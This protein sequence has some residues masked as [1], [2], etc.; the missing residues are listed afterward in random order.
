MSER[1]FAF[2]YNSAT[3][4]EYGQEEFSDLFAHGFRDG[5][6]YKRH[7][8]SLKV[9]VPNFGSASVEPGIMRMRGYFY[10][11]TT[12]ITLSLPAFTIGKSRT[13][14]VIVR[15]DT[16]AATYGIHA[17]AKK[18]TDG[19]T[20][21]PGLQNSGNVYELS[22]AQVK[23]DG[24][25]SVLVVAD[26]RDEEAVCGRFGSEVAASADL[27]TKLET[28]RL[29]GNAPFDGTK[30]ISLAEI[31]AMPA[32]TGVA[33]G[34]CTNLAISS[35]PGMITVGWDDPADSNWAGTLLVRK[36]IYGAWAHDPYPTS[37]TDGVVMLDNKVRNNYT[38]GLFY[39]RDASLD[40]QMT[41]YYRLFPYNA[42]GKVNM[43]ESNKLPSQSGLT[44][45]NWMALTLSSGISAANVAGG[46]LPRICKI[47]NHV[48]SREALPE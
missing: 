37:P 41:Y 16:S 11:N 13:D 38:Q 8:D 30:G 4:N 26:E 15:L 12:P 9:T 32:P 23:Y 48:P 43:S 3:D 1:Y 44:K 45:N 33:P 20:T 7:P 28:P 10:E 35:V 17:V 29:I 25:S 14:R 39:F 40:P 22:L 27:A 31:G 19:S 24:Q 36:A 5:V 46:S 2:N 34:P 47:G 42:F 18:G 6:C 21:P